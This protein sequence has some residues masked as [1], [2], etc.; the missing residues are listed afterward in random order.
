MPL[1]PH[2]KGGNRVIIICSD[3][4]EKTAWNDACT[5]ES[6]EHITEICSKCYERI[7]DL[8]PKSEVEGERHENHCSKRKRKGPY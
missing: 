8:K 1:L 7:F 3:C 5:I 6:T 2:R 4:K